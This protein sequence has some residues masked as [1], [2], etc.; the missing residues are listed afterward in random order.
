M[1][2]IL[3]FILCVMS[4]PVLAETPSGLP[5]P[6]FV[7]LKSDE[8]NVRTGPGTRYPIL[9]VYRKQNLPVEVVDEFELWRKIKDA[10][11]TIGWVYH[12][13]LSGRR[14]AQILGKQAHT[15]YIDASEDSKP[16]FKVAPGVLGEVDECS[17]HWCRLQVMGRKAWIQKHY[18][19][20][21]Y[22]HEQF[23]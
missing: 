23:D 14:Y 17:E 7:T 8:I 19:Y 9:W 1:R 20:G 6:R 18:L 21:I 2:T 22:P 15:M 13:M 10:D 5:V 16:R 4:A 12:T 3:I 11:G